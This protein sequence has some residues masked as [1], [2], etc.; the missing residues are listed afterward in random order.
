VKPISR[1]E[2]VAAAAVPPKL[3]TPEALLSGARVIEAARAPAPVRTTGRRI[4]AWYASYSSPAVV[5]MLRTGAVPETV[6]RPDD[7]KQITNT[8]TF[9][10]NCIC[11]LVITAETGDQFIGTGWLAGAQT[12]ITAGHCVY[13]HGYGGWARQVAVYPGGTGGPIVSDDL[14][15]TDSYA[16]SS[17]NQADDYGAILLPSQQ[18]ASF[19]FEALEDSKLS[20]L[21]VT[22]AGFPSDKDEG[23][24]W[25][26]TRKLVR[27]TSGQIFYDISTAGGQSGCP[28][29]Y[30]YHDEQLNQDQRLVVGIHNYGG[31][32]T[33]TATRITGAVYDQIVAWGGGK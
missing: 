26:N 2:F 9:P 17:A 11:W 22:V 1:K 6:F 32:T 7:R 14:Y 10:W 23:T 29:F 8:D 27:V 21:Q 12:V 25:G 13:L 15:T 31:T 19:G 24:L 18:T 16:A 4:D 33:N 28:V 3:G 30:N 5:A 20:H